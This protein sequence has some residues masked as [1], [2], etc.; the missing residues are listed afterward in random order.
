MTKP[1][2]GQS[3]KQKRQLKKAQDASVAARSDGQK[4]NESILS[5]SSKAAHYYRRRADAA[6][7][8]NVRL[9]KEQKKSTRRER[10]HK[11][12]ISDLKNQVKAA[13]KELQDAVAHGEA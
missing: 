2:K 7:A 5:P 10:R 1:R 4:E 8:E 9:K 13:E 12:Q 3:H 11:K 6:E